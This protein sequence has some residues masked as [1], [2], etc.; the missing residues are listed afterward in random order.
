MTCFLRTLC[1]GF[2]A[3]ILAGILSLQSCSSEKGVVVRS[4]LDGAAN[5]IDSSFDSDPAWLS[6]LVG[7]ATVNA[8]GQNGTTGGLG[9]PTVTAR[10]AEDLMQFIAAE[11]PLV[12]Q[13]EGTIVLPTDTQK[14]G[15]PGY[16]MHFVNS[17]KTIIGVG[18][19]ATIQAGGFGLGLYP[20]D[21][22][23]VS[24]PEKAIKN[25][26]I[27]NIT[28]D[29]TGGVEGE[30][31]GVNVFMF[32]HHIWI[33]HCTFKNSVDGS[34]DIKRGSSFI[35]VS[36][37]LFDGQAQP[38]ML[39][40]SLGETAFAQDGGNLKV[41]YQQNWFRQCHTRMPL[42]RFGEVHVLNNYWSDVVNH[43]IGIDEKAAIISENN[44]LDRGNFSYV[45][46]EDGALK[47]LGSLGGISHNEAR[48]T[49]RPQQYYVYTPLLTEDVKAYVIANA[50]AGK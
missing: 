6:G 35:T 34:V 18:D 10:S 14:N 49:W 46:S 25:I 30:T 5:K 13:V 15:F 29:G 40:H 24:L 26:I 39:G 19:A 3:C 12:I 32:T 45:Y 28:F 4:P 43:A 38:C 22:T 33:D 8:W 23:V 47:D 9:G 7:F 21:D 48:V 16:G 41:T 27:R 44:Y 36:N 1:G 20:F 31:D 17:D 42:A 37:N 11:G 2:G 50:G